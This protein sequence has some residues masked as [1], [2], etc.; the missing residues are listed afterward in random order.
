MQ[1]AERLEADN[2]RRLLKIRKLSLILDLDQTI[3]HATW[4]KQ[5]KESRYKNENKDIRQ[6]TLPGSDVV[7]YI[8]LR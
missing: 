6:F 1:E 3:V 5:V 4:D 8:K 2:A 7:Y